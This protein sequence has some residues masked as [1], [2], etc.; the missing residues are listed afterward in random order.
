MTQTRLRSQQWFNN[1][2]DPEMTALWVER[3]LNYGL[4]LEELRSCKLITP[5]K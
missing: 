5:L 1:I 4:T 2:D 3:S